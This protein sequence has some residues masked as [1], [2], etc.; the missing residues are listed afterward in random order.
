METKK[1]IGVWMDHSVAHLM[2]SKDNGILTSD[3]R[4]EF[5]HQ[6]KQ[7]ALNKNENIMHNKEQ[8]QQSGF[9][10]KISEAIKNHKEVLLFGPT[11]AKDELSNLLKADHHFENVKVEVKH[12]DK[13][14]ENQ[15]QAFVKEYFHIE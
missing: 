12:A 5:T 1:Q 13:M 15:R 8:Q 6:V 7:E 10:H 4:S 3:I 14:T 2:D 11:S 9:Y